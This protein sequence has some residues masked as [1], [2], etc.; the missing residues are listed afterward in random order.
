MLGQYTYVFSK[1]TGSRA[2]VDVLSNADL[3]KKVK[4]LQVLRSYTL[5]IAESDGSA[6]PSV[7]FFAG[8]AVEANKRCPDSLH[9]SW[10]VEDKPGDPD[11]R[12][13]FF[14][15]WHPKYDPCFWW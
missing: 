1:S 15:T 6:S 11:T 5:W 12:G 13:Q 4:P 9:D 3:L 7:G 2:F 10:V 14:K 8:K